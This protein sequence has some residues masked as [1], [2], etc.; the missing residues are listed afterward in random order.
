MNVLFAAAIRFEL[1]LRLG[2]VWLYAT[3]RIE[4][5]PTEL[6]YNVPEVFLGL[7]LRDLYCFLQHGHSGRETLDVHDEVWV[8]DERRFVISFLE[9]V[10]STSYLS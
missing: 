7:I 10:I 9:N 2:I 3:S 6:I 1:Q 4:N 8:I 5:G